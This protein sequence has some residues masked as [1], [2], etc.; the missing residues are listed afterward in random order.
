MAD[1]DLGEFMDVS[2][3][4]ARP[5]IRYG[6][7][8]LH[9]PCAWVDSFDTG[10]E[11]LVEDMFASMYAADGVGLAANQIGTSLRVFVYDCPDAS[12]ESRAGHVINPVLTTIGAVA[13]PMIGPEACLSVPGQQA[14]VSRAAVATV[15]GTDVCGRPVTVTGTGLLARCL[16]HETDHLGGI[17][18]VDLLPAG[19]RAAILAA[20]GLPGRHRRGGL[21]RSRLGRQAVGEDRLFP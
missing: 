16:Q 13:P 11:A 18:Y 15:T 12:G 14:E 21:D 9:R 10:L 2:A 19:E 8:V 6:A 7:A 1:G 17:V 5:V 3:G 4:T 20:A